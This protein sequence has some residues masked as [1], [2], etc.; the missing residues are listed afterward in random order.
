MEKNFK[1]SEK[2]C[3]K[4]LNEIANS[5]KSLRKENDL[6]QKDVANILGIRYQSYQ[7][8]EGE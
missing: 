5:L 8:Y 6:T 1:I 7:A 4:R 3:Y 2:D